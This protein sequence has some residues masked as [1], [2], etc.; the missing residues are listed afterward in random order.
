M[1]CC[2]RICNI[3]GSSNLLLGSEGRHGGHGKSEIGKGCCSS[4]LQQEMDK[5]P[6]HRRSPNVCFQIDRPKV[7]TYILV[8]NNST[9]IIDKHGLDID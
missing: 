2:R 9:M 5:G 6:P 7:I 8:R 4:E 3:A 1:L